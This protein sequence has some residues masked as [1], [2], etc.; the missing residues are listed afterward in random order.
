MDHLRPEPLTAAAFAAFGDVLDAAGPHRLINDGM[1]QRHDDLARLDIVDGRASVAILSARTR[2]LPYE[3]SLVERHPMGS[4]AFLPLHQQPFLVIV[5]PDEGGHPGQPRAFLTNG[6]QG[7]NFHRGTWHGVLTPLGGP[8]QPDT[9]LFAAI[10]RVGPGTNL[11][12]HRYAS[13]FRVQGDPSAWP[14]PLQAGRASS[15]RPG[16]RPST[17][18]SQPGAK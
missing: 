16:A 14:P 8:D 6:G 13:A 5:A 10:D 12:E 2:Q 1:C 7:I 11:E 9:A 17:K 4:Q 15:V 3:F 18:P